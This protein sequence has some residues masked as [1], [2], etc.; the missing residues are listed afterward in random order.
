MCYIVIFC[1]KE[2]YGQFFKFMNNYG[3]V[4]VKGN[5]EILR[6]KGQNVI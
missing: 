3:R 1:G 4:G 5:F 6:V 2:E